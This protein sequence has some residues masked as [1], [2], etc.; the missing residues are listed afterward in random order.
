[1]Q[2][3]IFSL[4]Q[5]ANQFLEEVH[6][7]IDIEYIDSKVIITYENEPTKL[8]EYKAVQKD[9]IEAEFHLEYLE[10]IKKDHPE[11]E[12]EVKS[13]IENTQRN[14]RNLKAK[15]KTLKNYI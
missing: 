11:A 6:K 14:I 4:E 10:T 8:Q 3:K 5:E 1:M 9:V 13:G 15:L 12:A 7:L 2:I